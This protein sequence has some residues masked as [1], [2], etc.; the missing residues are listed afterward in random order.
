MSAN[1]TA[2]RFHAPAPLWDALSTLDTA[3]PSVTVAIDAVDLPTFRH[4]DFFSL[5]SSS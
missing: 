1:R 5:V 4:S 2:R 3:P